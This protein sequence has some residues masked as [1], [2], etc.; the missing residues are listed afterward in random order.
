MKELFKL[1]TNHSSE[2][3]EKFHQLN[4]GNIGN[5][6]YWLNYFEMVKNIPGDIVECGI[7]RG[8]SLLIISA[9]NDI[10][11]KAEGGERKIYGYDSFEGFPEPSK[12]DDSYR[13]P[14]KGEWSTSPSGKYNYSEEFI[15][16]VL[17]EA[18]T[19]INN[20][21]LTKGFFGESLVN[22]PNDPIAILHVDGDLYQSYIDTLEHLY[23]KVSKGGLIVFDDFLAKKEDEDR[24]PG[25]RKAVEV[26]L[27][28]K[29]KNIKVSAR[30]TP[31][32]IK[33]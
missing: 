21:K 32:Y 14:K 33:D 28:D 30:G 15:K 3:D 11:N 2:I 17:T 16:L 29:A 31:Y 24:W 4:I 8:R 26:F 22:H 13:K 12:E 1:E 19:P 23:P 27:G 25:A 9:L 20:L 6:I 5:V 7:G 18:K 10:L